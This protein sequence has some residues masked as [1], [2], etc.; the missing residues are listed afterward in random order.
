VN[1]PKEPRHPRPKT[2]ASRGIRTDKFEEL[3]WGNVRPAQKTIR[4]TS[5]VSNTGEPRSVPIHPTLAAWL[6]I[7]PR[8]KNDEKVVPTTFEAMRRRLRTKLNRKRQ[9]DGQDRAEDRGCPWEIREAQK[10]QKTQR[11]AFAAAPGKDKRSLM[12]HPRL[13]FPA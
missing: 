13:A 8:G 3:H 11:S 9:A 12:T 1:T 4:A 5:A 6:E 7:L 10:Q 2:G